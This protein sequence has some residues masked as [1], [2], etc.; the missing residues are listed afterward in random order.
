MILD[1]LTAIV[2][3]YMAS[4]SAI[5]AKTQEEWNAEAAKCYQRLLPQ[6]DHLGD[7][8]P[9]VTPINLSGS[10]ANTIS[11]IGKRARS[12]IILPF[13][14][15]STYRDRIQNHQPGGALFVTPNWVEWQTKT[16]KQK[17]FI[18]S[19]QDE[20]TL[21]KSISAL[22]Q[23]LMT[24]LLAFPIQ[25]VHLDIVDL[26]NKG[27]SMFLTTNLPS[28]LFSYITSYEGLM[29]LVSRLKD[30]VESDARTTGFTNQEDYNEL[31]HEIIGV[32]E[33]VVVLPCTQ[34]Q[35]D[36][37]QSQ[38][39]P[40]FLT[41]NKNGTYFFVLD[42][43]SQLPQ[44]TGRDGFKN[45]PEVYQQINAKEIN[46]F[47]GQEGADVRT[48]SV[49]NNPEWSK[50]AFAYIAEE[51]KK[52]HVQ[53]QDWKAVAEAQYPELM[54]NMDVP[55]GYT[56]DKKPFSFRMDVNLQHYHAFVIGA[57]GSGKSRFL[58]NI[59]L[60]LI[61]AYK[62]EDLKLYL[63][64]FK[65]VEFN[66]Y[67][68]VKH[69]RALLA[70]R[71]DERITYEVIRDLKREMEGRQRLLAAADASDVD[72]YNTRNYGERIPQI[73]LIADECQTL[74]AERVK[75]PGLQYEMLDTLAL[76]AQEG[77][78][79]GVHLL[80]ATQSL[81]NAPLLGKDILNQISEH[82]ILPCR[83]ADALRL[84]PEENRVATEKI[85]SQ[86]EKGRG[87]CYYQGAE[88]DKLFTFNFV[89]KGEMQQQL[90]AA[91]IKKAEN[92]NSN[93]QVFFSGSLNFQFSQQVAEEAARRGDGLVVASPGQKISLDL[94][95]LSFWL[96]RR[97][98]ENILLMG[99]NDDDVQPLTRTTI[100]TLY[101]LVMTS[102]INGLNY[103]F[104][105]FD[106]L[107]ER[108]AAYK[109]I[110]QA[111]DQ[112]NMC[113]VVGE[114][115]RLRCIKELCDDIASDDARPTILT[116]IGQEHFT[117]LFNDELL[118]PEGAGQDLTAVQKGEFEKSLSLINQIYPVGDKKRSDIKKVR[119][120]FNYILD[121]GPKMG[122][123][124]VMQIEKP[125]RYLFM[126]SF[127]AQRDVYSRFHHCIFLRS[128]DTVGG[129]MML[130]SE[131][132][133]EK[134][135]TNPDR[136]RAYYY[137]SIKDRYNLFTPY[138]LPTIENK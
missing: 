82:Y 23:M 100:D 64:D 89:Q 57:T 39:L 29:G 127:S 111:M 97:S 36:R 70:D 86:M 66:C 113:E 137:D 41:G 54:S 80:L 71:A 101:S 24:I 109:D 87:L 17:N 118:E 14:P 116:I 42:D 30:D 98:S 99:I 26:S 5:P 7:G 90:L 110:L 33:L 19:Y 119:E 76:I 84:V 18:F 72:E 92:H 4:L 83:T 120:A 77:R 73:I 125:S 112:A 132:R 52:R 88:E 79:Y 96:K 1:T 16:N 62:P 32:Y 8:D 9:L 134:L 85:V 44:R 65:G 78:A 68:E 129:K 45:H 43:A 108:G 10:A 114:K 51:A 138:M 106:C 27:Y 126:D 58:H 67:R 13:I 21:K 12:R 122:I 94:E 22:N 2:K 28:N 105:V 115:G 38:L 60:S 11:I 63:M 128:D 74:F 93:G 40:Y 55:I 31:Q 37:V 47:E 20:A 136:L 53:N 135:E 130:P 81:A 3:A 104:V 117:E 102:R 123:H 50:A 121:K 95:P 107:D 124:T 131:I 48:V 46:D 6:F 75:N 59:I 103:R 69:V 61:T 15:V 34:D 91:A 25:K 49:A 35:E 133:L 56:S